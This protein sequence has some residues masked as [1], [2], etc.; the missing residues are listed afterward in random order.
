MKSITASSVFAIKC[1]CNASYTKPLLGLKLDIHASQKQQ[2]KEVRWKL[3]IANIAITAADG[4]FDTFKCL[5]PISSI[6]LPL[7][8][9]NGI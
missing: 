2:E 7:P 6:F 9:I 3:S 1:F 5:H 8:F 4:P